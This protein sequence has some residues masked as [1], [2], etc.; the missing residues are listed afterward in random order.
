L[1]KYFLNQ[2]FGFFPFSSPAFSL[3]DIYC[4][5]SALHSARAGLRAQARA[6]AAVRRGSSRRS[7]RAQQAGAACSA[8]IGPRRV[9]AASR[10]ATR[11]SPARRERPKGSSSVACGLQA[12]CLAAAAAE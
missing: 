3:L 8:Q 7:G 1:T 5:R 11:H 9:R 6:V 2:R 4:S 12:S 10:L